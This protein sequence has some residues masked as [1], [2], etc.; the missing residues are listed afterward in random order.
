MAKKT[1]KNASSNLRP[2]L[3]LAEL[4]EKYLDHMER[5]GKSAGTCFSYGMELKAAQGELGAETLV[6]MLTTDDVEKFNNSTRVTKLK[7]GRPKSQ[8]SIDKTRRVLR[9][10][11]TW[12]AQKGWIERS[13]IPTKG[14]GDA[15]ETPAPTKGK[16]GRKAKVIEPALEVPQEVAEA[17]ADAVE[18]SLNGAHAE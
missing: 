15:P 4:S 17:A 11:L 10:A 8:L 18:P 9:L 13:P 7:S 5:E 16:G 3:T 12:A 6:G 1:T 14:D 2:E